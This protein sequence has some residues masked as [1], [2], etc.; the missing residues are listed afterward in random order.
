MPHLASH[1]VLVG[2]KLQRK[3]YFIVLMLLA[4]LA[5]ATTVTPVEK[6][7]TISSSKPLLLQQLYQ[8]IIFGGEVNVVGLASNRTPTTVGVAPASVGSPHVSDIDVY[9]ATLFA[10]A[11]LSSWAKAFIQASYSQ[12]SPSFLR[13]LP[14]GGD[15]FFL[16]KGYVTIAD[17]TRT[18]FYMKVGRQFLDFGGISDWSFLE[19]F[20]QLLSLTRATTLTAGFMN[21]HHFEGSLYVYQ[22]LSAVS[23]SN[24]SN[25]IRDYGLNFNYHQ[26][27][28][29]ISYQLGIGYLSNLSNSLYVSSTKALNSNL[30]NKDDYTH[31]VGAIDLYGNVNI[32]AIS[33]GMKYIGA[34]RAF[35]VNDV[36]YTRNAGSTF[37]G[38]QPAV[39]GMYV[40]YAL[41]LF[42]YDTQIKIG[43]E[44]SKESVAV[45]TA[46]GSTAN[47]I[48]G[49]Y[50]KFFA[51]GLPKT[52]YY[53]NYKVD[54]HQ[55]LSVGVELAQEGSYYA[56]NGGTNRNS[57]T[58]LMML[59]A[60]LV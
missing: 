40:G 41:P 3:I 50:G 6:Q 5:L 23:D 13:S 55:S 43:Y 53:I 2:M 31:A 56:S 21:F 26:I 15:V 7:V 42:A 18:P 35:S 28:R 57:W 48:S 16:D 34:L 32:H 49:V 25:R 52:R 12:S 38:A 30:G 10:N 29:A 27:K 19:S 24:N 60:R 14:G 47:S 37:I 46:S 44:G 36:P 17:S 11:T 4:K 51:I 9:L 22:G 20:T 58:G 33:V 54:C 1:G 59:I 8:R 45:G 39:W